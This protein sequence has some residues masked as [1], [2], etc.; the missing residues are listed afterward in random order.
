MCKQQFAN[1]K[2]KRIPQKPHYFMSK[3]VLIQLLE[4]W[5]YLTEL[6]AFPGSYPITM[7][8]KHHISLQIP[9]KQQRPPGISSMHHNWKS[10]I[11]TSSHKGRMPQKYLLQERLPLPKK[12]ARPVLDKHLRPSKQLPAVASSQTFTSSHKNRVMLHRCNPL[13]YF[14]W[15]IRSNL[16]VPLHGTD[17][18]SISGAKKPR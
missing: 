17:A 4:V 9:I 5:P 8:K 11:R 3:A 13:I 7:R 18:L 6:Y 2:N 14:S 1:E 16:C 15:P 12:A 10:E